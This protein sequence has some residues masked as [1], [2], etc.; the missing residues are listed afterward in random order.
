MTPHQPM[1]AQAGSQT[2]RRPSHSGIVRLFSCSSGGWSRGFPFGRGDL[3]LP[4]NGGRRGVHFRRNQSLLQGE[5][6]ALFSFQHYFVSSSSNRLI[7]S[8]SVC[9]FQI[10][11]FK[12]PRYVLFVDSYPLTPSGK[13][14]SEILAFASEMTY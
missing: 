5:G 7:G 11:H 1:N 10:S 6:D 4:Q 14:I 13:V 12:I 9:S 2:I 3:R 8:F